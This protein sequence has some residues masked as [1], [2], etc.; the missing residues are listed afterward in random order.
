MEEYKRE[1]E[2]TKIHGTANPNTFYWPQTFPNI[3]QVIDSIIEKEAPISR[4]LLESKVLAIW[5]ITRVGVK[6]ENILET[7]YVKMS[8][9]K[10]ISNDIIFFWRK[11]QNPEEY[12]E[13]R[14]PISTEDIRTMDNICEEEIANAILDVVRIQFSMSKSD[15]IKE[16]AKVFGFNELDEVMQKSIENGIQKAKERKYIEISKDGQKISLIE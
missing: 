9:K 7:L 11:D 13:Y 14:V 6:V 3:M 15:L 12:L 2:I 10:S 1:Y 5:Q 8:L 4:K 16:T